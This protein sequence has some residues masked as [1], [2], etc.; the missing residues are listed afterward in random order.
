MCVSIPQDK[1]KLKIWKLNGVAQC[2]ISQFVH[3]PEKPP[4][5][6][7]YLLSTRGSLENQVKIRKEDILSICHTIFE[8][9]IQKWIFH[10][11]RIVLDG[12]NA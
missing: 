4:H 5:Y 12:A 2:E 11:L 3:N 7:S 8:A 1:I 6:Q 9:T 10:V